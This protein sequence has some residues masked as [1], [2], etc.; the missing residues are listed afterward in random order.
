MRWEGPRVGG[1]GR[2]RRVCACVNICGMFAY[3]VALRSSGETHTYVFSIGGTNCDGLCFVGFRRERVSSQW[4]VK[5]SVLDLFEG[6]A[7]D[8]SAGESTVKAEYS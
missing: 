2:A 1:W 7:L 5:S 6:D 3:L 8:R 4:R